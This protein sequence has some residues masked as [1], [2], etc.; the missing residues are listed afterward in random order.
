MFVGS[1]ANEEKVT[2]KPGNAT[3]LVN[4][5]EN[6]TFINSFFSKKGQFLMENKRHFPQ[7]KFNIALSSNYKFLQ[8]NNL[9]SYDKTMK[10]SILQML[11]QW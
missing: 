8:V 6:E 4:K 3:W 2:A 11:L 9:Y 7:A 1:D 5:T 10:I